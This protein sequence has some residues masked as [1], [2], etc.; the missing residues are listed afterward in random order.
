MTAHMAR[1][2]AVILDLSAAGGNTYQ[3]PS[4][5]RKKNNARKPAGC[6]VSTHT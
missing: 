3:Q 2:L 6:A 4:S 1:Q 5:C